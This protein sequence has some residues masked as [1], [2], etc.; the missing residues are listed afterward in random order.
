M[1]GAPVTFGLAV[2]AQCPVLK[3]MQLRH[4]EMEDEKMIVENPRQFANG[5]NVEVLQLIPLLNADE[6][7]G[8]QS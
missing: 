2:L 4:I 8:E 6:L 1:L 5:A 7:Q 3:E